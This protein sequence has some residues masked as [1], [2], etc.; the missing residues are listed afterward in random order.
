MKTYGRNVLRTAKTGVPFDSLRSLRVAAMAAA[1]MGSGQAIA[2]TADC[3]QIT[4]FASATYQ[5]SS[6]DGY[7]VSYAVTARVQAATP[8]VITGK[9]AT[10]TIQGSG[11]QVTFCITF[12][13]LSYCASA[14]NVMIH[15]RVPDGMNYNSGFA[16]ASWT[17][18]G[19]V[20]SPYW[21][22]NGTPTW[23]AGTPTPPANGSATYYLR[24]VFDQLDPRESGVVCF[25]ASVL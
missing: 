6:L 4:N 1:F 10:P 25:Q 8:G 23:N 17:S 22:L 9:T 24:W 14:F 7:I 5:N 3:S 2:A 11:G 20:P 13:N 16:L 19:G 12:Q 18:S 15:D 21:N